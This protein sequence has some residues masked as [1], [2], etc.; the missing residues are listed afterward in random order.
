MC[1]CF[2]AKWLLYREEEGFN[3]KLLKEIQ[4]EDVKIYKT[5]LRMTPVQFEFNLEKVKP[6]IIKQD[7]YLRKSIG[8]AERLQVTLRYFATRKIR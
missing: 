5:V 1:S 2:S 6:S 3:H 4:D 7:T 8:P